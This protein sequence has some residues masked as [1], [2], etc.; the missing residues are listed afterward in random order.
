MIAVAVGDI[1]GGQVLATRRDPFHCGVRL[2]DGK[3]GVDE[4]S[5]PFTIDKSGRCRHPHPLFLARWQVAVETLAFCHKDIP[6]QRSTY[7]GGCH[8]G[9]PFDGLRFASF[10]DAPLRADGH[11]ASLPT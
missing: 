5:V 6:F 2:L 11:R 9:S 3:K 4:D 1:D 7:W 10:R 8:F